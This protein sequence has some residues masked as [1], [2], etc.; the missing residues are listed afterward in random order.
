VNHDP[1]SR[2]L[3]SR[4]V[5]RGS[6]VSQPSRYRGIGVGLVLLALFGVAFALSGL[7]MGLPQPAVGGSCGPGTTSESSIVA[8]FD[9]GSIGAGQEPPAA[10]TADRADWMAF[11]GEC[12]A[13]ADSRV[14][15]TF[16]I[17]MVSIGVA[18]AGAML[19]LRAT[20]KHPLSPSLVQWVPADG[21]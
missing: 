13:S 6:N 12:Q 20:R 15:A 8:L 10:R 4:S 2:V 17:L 16:V 19:A 3:S 5:E 1:R 7:L 11:V 18:L 21:G 14:L 9:P